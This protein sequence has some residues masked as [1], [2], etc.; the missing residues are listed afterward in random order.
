MAFWE[1]ENNIR[2]S[3]FILNTAP[4]RDDPRLLEKCRQI[5]EFG[6]EIGIHTNSITK[7][8]VKGIE[9]YEDLKEQISRF[10]SAG[11]RISG[12]S[13]HGDRACYE[14][15]FINYWMF[16]G[17]KTAEIIE[18]ESNKNAEGIYES[19]LRKR[20]KYPVNHKL[21]RV[22][23]KILDLWSI[24][25]KNLGL[26]YEASHLISDAYFTDSGGLWKRSSDPINEGLHNKRV[27]VLI[28][29]IHW[30][31]PRKI[32]FFLS[33]ARSGSKWLATILD[34]ASSCI[35][36]HEY[37]LNHIGDVRKGEVIEEK[38]TG[39]RLHELL[40]SENKIKEGLEHTRQLVD[41]QER[42]YAEVNVYLPLVINQLINKFPDAQLIHIHR[43]PVDVVRSV[44][45]RGWYDT[46]HDTAH[47]ANL[48][49]G[50]GRLTPF[51]KCCHYV[52]F[53]NEILIRRCKERFAFE[54]MTTDPLY[55]YRLLKDLGIAFYP[56]LSKDLIDRKINDN[57]LDSFPGFKEWSPAN[58]FTYEKQLAEVAG[59]LGYLKKTNTYSNRFFSWLKLKRNTDK[60]SNEKL[61][62]KKEAIGD[63]SLT[64]IVAKCFVSNIELTDK[65]SSISITALDSNAHAYFLFK[66]GCWSRLEG[67]AG[68][69]LR[70]NG[71]YTLNLSSTIPQ[72]VKVNLF[73]LYYDKQRQQVYKR[74]L[75]TLEDGACKKVFAFASMGNSHFFN[76]A[77][78]MPKQKLQ[79]Q[80]SIENIDLIFQI[81]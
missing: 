12:T 58:I 15:N 57:K 25:E 55:V 27:Q 78:Y 26:T 79:R 46:P 36:S 49:E 8:F 53:I 18:R 81:Y 41:Y 7:W 16:S 5:Q 40:N 50:W 72:R 45:N 42:D 20:I 63:V 69:K 28:H 35:A 75:G 33:T 64:S 1:K 17:L 66:G 61:T 2:A 74:A 65:Q 54:K 60:D 68:W 9:P 29:P 71:Y 37:T 80:A 67:G 38:K 47:P 56:L 73:C 14:H 52:Q 32:Y 31:A 44:M 6:H 4:Y 34:Q 22:D 13:A 76:L 59:N 77:L 62:R 3:Y 48:I 39:H 70:K 23:G 19:E 10:R 30:R 24:N 21:K 51:E 11:V 43:N